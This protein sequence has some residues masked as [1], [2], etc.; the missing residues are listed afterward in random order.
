MEQKE[1]EL[2][3]VNESVETVKQTKKEKE[4]K[5]LDCDVISYNNKS[6]ILDVDFK[7]YGVRLTNINNFH[8]TKKVKIKY[9]GEIGKPNFSCFL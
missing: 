2:T 4:S 3:V 6:K 7:G 1:K 9:K 5:F 8:N